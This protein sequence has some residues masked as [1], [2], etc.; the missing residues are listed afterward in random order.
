MAE[1]TV[2]IKDVVIKECVGIGAFGKGKFSL[3]IFRSV[4]YFLQVSNRFIEWLVYKGSWH[5]DVAVKMLPSL[6][7][8]QTDCQ[9]Q[10]F[11]SEVAML[12]YVLKNA[13]TSCVIQAKH[14]YY[15]VSC[16]YNVYRRCRHENIILFMGAFTQPP[17]LGIVM[18]WC[19]GS[20][21]YHH[22]HVHVRI[23]L[24]VPLS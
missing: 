15:L 6:S 7:H 10:D 13:I 17:D 11:Y 16:L 18:E 2:D 3:H 8:S 14:G 9:I 1:F 19:A 4:L 23:M 20:T 5:G 24:Y 12:M 21:L 22:L